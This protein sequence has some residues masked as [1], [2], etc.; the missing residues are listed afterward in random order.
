[1]RNWRYSISSSSTEGRT[2][3]MSSKSD[4]KH[5][6]QKTPTDLSN[7][8][9]IGGCERLHFL[10]C[11]V[12]EITR[13]WVRTYILP[14]CKHELC[15]HVF[16]ELSVGSERLSAQ[17]FKGRFPTHVTFKEEKEKMLSMEWFRMFST[18][19]Q[20]P[21]W[22][23][24]GGT[25]V[26]SS[27]QSPVM[28]GIYAK[29]LQLSP[30]IELRNLPWH[31]SHFERAA[32]GCEE[33]ESHRPPASRRVSYSGKK[34]VKGK[35]QQHSG[36]LDTE[37]IWGIQIDPV[38][39]YNSSHS[40]GYQSKPVAPGHLAD[41]SESPIAKKM[42]KKEWLLICEE[43]EVTMMAPENKPHVSPLSKSMC[44]PTEIAPALSPQ[45]AWC[46]DQNDTRKTWSWSDIVTLLGSPPKAAMFCWTHCKANR[47]ARTYASR[48]TKLGSQGTYD[49]VGRHLWVPCLL[50]LCQPETRMLEYG[51]DNDFWY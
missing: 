11:D 16:D 2:L 9:W 24:G 47:S 42:T 31:S 30:K 40:R 17:I 51:W 19:S 36:V 3:P 20:A 26:P 43:I 13:K 14:G 15:P 33:S 35:H 49:R 48:L 25:Y 44:R 18:D 38:H 6:T 1:M 27:S 8:V 39:R 32:W 4:V 22:G 23:I 12:G 37:R 5:L 50:L 7:V 28:K 45:L 21:A 10:I 41:A 46:E 29:C 34:W